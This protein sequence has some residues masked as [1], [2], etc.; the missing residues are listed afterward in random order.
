[1]SVR[2]E[3]NIFENSQLIHIASEVVVLCGITFYV[4]AQNRKMTACVDELTQKLEEKEERF[5]KLENF[6]QQISGVIPMINQKLQLHDNNINVL[7]ERFSS[8]DQPMVSVNT[9]NQK[10]GE[11]KGIT[12]HIKPILKEERP[13]ERVSKIQF[14]QPIAVS[15]AVVSDLEDLSDSDL[16]NEISEELAE[17]EIDD[18]SL[19][20]ED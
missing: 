12:R 16:D 2:K 10:K 14:K 11:M 17:L 7:N 3:I 18:S 9:R 4:V 20:K 1:M 8:M 15:K 6:M 19:K 5:V 13:V